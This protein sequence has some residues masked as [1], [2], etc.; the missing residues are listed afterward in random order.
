MYNLGIKQVLNLPQQPWL[1]SSE[2]QSPSGTTKIV[3]DNTDFILPA[4]RFKLSI[5]QIHQAPQETSLTSC[6]GWHRRFGLSRAVMTSRHFPGDINAIANIGRI[7]A[8]AGSVEVSALL[9]RP[10][11]ITYAEKITQKLW[12]LVLPTSRTRQVTI[13]PGC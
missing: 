12:D 11:S 3:A 4:K 7:V 5:V 8:V 9:A 2:E 1:E 10:Y 6:T 13:K